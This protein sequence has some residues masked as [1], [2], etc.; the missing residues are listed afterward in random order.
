MTDAVMSVAALLGLL[1][2]VLLGT[3]G[4]GLLQLFRMRKLSDVTGTVVARDRQFAGKGYWTYPVV[5]FTT[6]DG[7]QI[8]RT[9]RQLARP[10][11]GRKLRIIYDPSAPDGQRRST[12]T[13]L[14]L[15]SSQPLIY[16]VWMVLWFWLE[17]TAGLAGKATGAG[18]ADSVDG[19]YGKVIALPG[20]DASMAITLV[21]RL[22]CD[23]VVHRRLSYSQN[24][25]IGTPSLTRPTLFIGLVTG[26]LEPAH[27]S[28][29][30]TYRDRP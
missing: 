12:S 7:T 27:V 21:I 1:G 10:A 6:R 28:A 15:V 25:S 26:G 5:E 9:F 24:W 2:L 16:S 23:E 17:I 20:H 8:R 14:T 3:A 4:R 22:G 29:P 13:G 19:Q 30:I 18:G 11:I